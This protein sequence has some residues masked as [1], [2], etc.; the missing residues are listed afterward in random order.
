MSRVLSVVLSD[1][2]LDAL[3]TL[4][5]RDHQIIDDLV[6]EAVDNYL[7]EKGVRRAVFAGV[8]FADV[9]GVHRIIVR[10][11]FRRV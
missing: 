9:P 6:K 7:R 3:E 8:A 11:G 2:H 1:W 10:G 5:S 4:A